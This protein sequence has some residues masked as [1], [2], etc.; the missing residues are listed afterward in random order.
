MRP[1]LCDRYRHAYED[2]E[3]PS[4][5]PL[6]P[7][8]GNCPGRSSLY[9]PCEDVACGN[10]LR[11]AALRIRL[12]DP[13]LVPSLLEFLTGSVNCVAKQVGPREIDVSLLGSYDSEIHDLTVDLLVRAWE[14]AHP[15]LAD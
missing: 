14:A 2:L 12:T 8:S 4:R 10:V 15:D 13:A 9:D 1:R 3:L 6:T 5:S 11:P 7:F